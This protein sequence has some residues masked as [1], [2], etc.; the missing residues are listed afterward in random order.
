MSDEKLIVTKN[1]LDALATSIATKAG[2]A[3]P[4][5]IAQMKI[6]VDN[7]V[8]GTIT[9]D[10]NGYLVIG[11]NGAAGDLV[12]RFSIDD[13]VTHNYPSIINLT[14][15]EIT[16]LY[17]YQFAGSDIT[18]I[19]APYITTFSDGNNIGIGMFRDCKNL[20]VVDMPMLEN[21]GSNGYQFSKCT[22]L[23]TINLPLTMPGQYCFNECSNL[24]IAVIGVLKTGNG[25]NMNS[26]DFLK[27]TKLKKVDIKT[28]RV[29]TSSFSDCTVL[30]TVIIRSNAVP[31]LSN[32]N[33]FTNTPFASGKSGGTLYVPSALISDYQS[34]TN[35]ST[36]LGYTNNSITS[37]EDSIYETQYADGT[38][39][40]S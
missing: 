14:N 22:S 34:A 29:Y 39:I 12:E 23:Q 9:Q 18:E 6:A 37:I 33:A 35:W 16:T 32:I 10:E 2:V 25:G 15:P 24:E 3:S 21:P 8:C 40:S 11:E 27:C 4:L 30:D 38:L 36:I 28:T 17:P 31:T 26:N 5:T 7:L 13:I 20:V 19:H 1:K